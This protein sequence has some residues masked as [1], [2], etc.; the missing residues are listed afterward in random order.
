MNKKTIIIICAAIV[1]IA[2]VGCALAGVFDGFGQEKV[3]NDDNTF[4]VGF[5]AE[6]PPYGYKADNGSYVGFDLDLA[7]EVAKRNNWTFVA[8]PIDWDSKDA[9]LQSGS[10]D[11]IWNGFTMN[12]RE[13]DYTW[14]DAYIDNKQVILV[15]ADSNIKSISDLA[16]KTV[17]VQKD[18]SAESALKGD[19]KTIADT[20]KALT[21]VADYNTAIM[22]LDSG[23]CDAV[24]MD[25]G[26]AKYQVNKTNGKYIIL[27]DVI[28]SEQYGIG[29]KL[30]NTALRDQVQLTLLEMAAD[31]TIAKIAAKY[32]EYGIPTS[33]CL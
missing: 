8:Q 4:I 26:V 16:G 18:S 1:C 21:S 27:N 15:K 33:L 20:F 7:Q 5:D 22:D 13:K 14:S 24:A 2:I 25:E 31:G 6:F 23:A 28:S 30:G 9:E 19:N 32:S 10:I 11:C 17:E 3:V 12:G 29:F